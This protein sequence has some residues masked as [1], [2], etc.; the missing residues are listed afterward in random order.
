MD[1]FECQNIENHLT[2][3]G[4]RNRKNEYKDFYVLNFPIESLQNFY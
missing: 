1:I 3:E 4:K 2:L